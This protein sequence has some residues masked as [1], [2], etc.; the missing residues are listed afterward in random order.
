MNEGI[1]SSSEE[2]EI[3]YLVQSSTCVHI[4]KVDYSQGLGLSSVEDF[5]KSKSHKFTSRRTYFNS[6]LY[7][8][9]KQPWDLTSSININSK[10][11]IP[12]HVWTINI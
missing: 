5:F 7:N 11:L 1:I 2:R 10:K 4:V 6:K 3:C 8:W 9:K 12:H